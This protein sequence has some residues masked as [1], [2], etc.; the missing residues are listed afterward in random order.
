MESI[1]WSKMDQRQTSHIAD[2][3]QIATERVAAPRPRTLL[4]VV[5]AASGSESDVI[6]VLVTE[7]DFEC[8]HSLEYLRG[9]HIKSA[10]HEPLYVR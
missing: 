6:A 4:R 7:H 3:L 1:T 5:L 2:A 10:F 8:G 9:Y